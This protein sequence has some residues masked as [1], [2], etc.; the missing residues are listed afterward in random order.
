LL[1]LHR[2]PGFF[3]HSMLFS[4]YFYSYLEFGSL[5]NIGNFYVR[6]KQ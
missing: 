3:F 5:F 1:E 6:T 4:P 2:Q